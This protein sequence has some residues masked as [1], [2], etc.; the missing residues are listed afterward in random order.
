MRQQTIGQQ[1]EIEG[2][3]L[4]SW[5]KSKLVF[6]PGGK[7]RHFLQTFGSAGRPRAAGFVVEGG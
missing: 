4:H 5:L 7:F 3:G 2:I 6:K 1:F